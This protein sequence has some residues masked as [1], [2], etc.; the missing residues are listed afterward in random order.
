MRN[1]RGIWEIRYSDRDPTD[2]AKR[3][4]KT[5]STKLRDRVLAE[6]YRDGWLAIQ[7][8]HAAQAV[9]TTPTVAVC[10]DLYLD[11]LR[12]RGRTNSM[13]TA[14][15]WPKRYWGDR[16]PH[17]L[18]DDLIEDYAERRDIYMRDKY[19]K[20][21]S[22]ST[23]YLEMSSVRAA[24]KFALKKGLM[25][26]GEMPREF[27]VPKPGPRREVWL[28]EDQ[29]A[30]VLEA[31]KQQAL[32]P[33]GT[34]EFPSQREVGLFVYIA[35]CTGARR[36]AILELTWDRIDFSAQP[37][38]R[39][40]FNVPGREETNKRRADGVPIDSRLLPVLEHAKAHGT[41]TGK[42]FHCRDLRKSYDTLMKKLGLE[43]VNM[44]ALRHSFATLAVRRGVPLDKVAGMLADNLKTV[45]DTYHHHSPDHLTD[46]VL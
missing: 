11:H 15:V 4:S 41:G 12:S 46:A 25:A 21:H 42:L 8:G 44:H 9:R 20:S 16:L 30:L 35:L 40:A 24:L 39:I 1:E 27:T 37:K 34:L 14:L 19:G 17:E 18:N 33:E 13:A 31:A 6:Q 45:I 23:L 26:P 22:P 43:H 3:R 28:N 2:P 32:A 38:G 29:A 36:G 10:A 5:H 7:R